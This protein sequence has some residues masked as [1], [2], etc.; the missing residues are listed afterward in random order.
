MADGASFSQSPASALVAS[1]ADKTAGSCEY[2][3]E[4]G[5]V[6]LTAKNVADAFENVKEVLSYLPSNKLDKNVYTGIED[7]PNRATPEIASVIASDGYNAHG[8]I[9]SIADGGKYLELCSGRG[10]SMITAFMTVNGIV[11]G[12]VANDPSVRDGKL[13]ASALNKA[14]GFINLC[15]SFGISVL[16][17]VDT[18]GYC[19]RCEAKG[20]KMPAESASLAMA[21]CKASVPLVTVN[22]GCAY[23]TAF[24]VMGSKSLGADVVFALD[25]AKLGV[26]D[27]KASVS[28]M[29]TE[30]LIGAKAPIE[31]RKALEEEWALTMSTPL[32][33]AYAGQ[34]DDIIPAEEMRVK[35][36]S[37]LEMLSMKNDFVQ[38]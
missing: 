2:A 6:S 29:W 4:K 16:T 1:G 34:V 21:Y 24:T 33:A 32:M 19:S 28:M 7:D 9:A 18:K 15:D 17:L 23:G 8:V 31:K 3:S 5:L 13:S 11:C 12:V 26:L 27:P 38:L 22:V 14:S 37:A 36:A 10:A 25:S 20:N 35:I 30:K